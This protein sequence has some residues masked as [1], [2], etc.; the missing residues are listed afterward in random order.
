[1]CPYSSPGTWH[2]VSIPREVATRKGAPQISVAA[3]DLPRSLAPRMQEIHARS[4]IRFQVPFLTLGF[5]LAR[6]PRRDAPTL[7]EALSPMVVGLQPASGGPRL[8]LRD[9]L[10]STAPRSVAPANEIDR[11]KDIP[12]CQFLVGL[13]ASKG[14]GL[15]QPQEIMNSRPFRLL[16]GFL[17]LTLTAFS[18]EK[19]WGSEE[20]VDVKDSVVKI[21]ATVRLP[22]V[23]KPWMKAPPHD[24]VG[25][26]VVIAG[27]RILCSAHG[28]LYASQVEVQG[29]RGEKVLAEVEASSI[30]LDVAVLKLEDEAFFSTHPAMPLLEGL[31]AIGDV[32][33]TYGYPEGGSTLSVTAGI[34]SRIESIRFNLM[35]SAT[36]IQVD[37]AI[38]PGNSGGP[39]MVGNKMAGLILSKLTGADKVGYL[40]SSEEI[41]DFLRKRSGGKE[42]AKPAL[43]DEFQALENQSLREFLQL[44]S[45]VEGILVRKPFRTEPTYPLKEFDV[46]TRIGDYPI[47]SSGL[48][49]L[50]DSG[51]RISFRYLVPKLT[52]NGSVA[53]TIIREG[54]RRVVQAPTP[55][56]LHYVI[57]SLNGGYPA[58]FIYG[59]LV[60]SV[61]TAEPVI[62]EL[63]G[64][65]SRPFLTRLIATE[66][67]I[68]KRWGEEAIPSDRRLVFVASFLPS[69]GARGYGD[70]WLQVLQSVNGVPITNL[71]HLVEVLR[72]A[73]TT[74]VT[75]DFANRNCET[76]VFQREWMM[77][78]TTGILVENGIRDQGSPELLEIWNSKPSKS[79]QASMDAGLG[80]TEG[81][82]AAP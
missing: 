73:Q 13:K 51:L 20:P 43:L 35:H 65:N 68:L 12:F 58:Y 23:S 47:D 29:S 52:T 19:T 62:E 36:C 64:A 53:L 40:V 5:R 7:Y 17:S 49:K 39:G 55:H 80:P 21:I 31:P 48:I 82:L 32:V 27:H 1:M 56:T 9:V 67:P 41:V 71:T 25:S 72:D 78:A 3:L 11:K 33:R 42:T 2:K 14:S 24:T 37:A 63:S 22:A 76:M 57:P 38:N 59:P 44:D 50:P 26:G 30:A 15:F 74:F 10:D 60:F 34:V 8:P 61:V 79:K 6:F 70:P 77:K 18:T 69:R 66:S 4:L 81:S 45:S 46:V 28:V 75:F 54:T 16:V